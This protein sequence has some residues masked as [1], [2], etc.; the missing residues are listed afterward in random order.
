MEPE[1]PLV[2]NPFWFFGVFFASLAFLHWLLI[3]V[4]KLGKRQWKEIDY[5]WISMSTLA[6]FGASTTLRKALATRAIDL[7]SA[8]LQGSYSTLKFQLENLS[9]GAV[10]RTFIRTEMS[11]PDFDEIEKEFD[12][13]CKYG[14][15]ARS[16]LTKEPPTDERA[17]DD[18][19]LKDRPPVKDAMLNSI[20]KQYDR[21]YEWFLET[22]DAYNGVRSRA[23]NSL[24]DIIVMLLSPHLLAIALALRMT[25]VTGELML[26][27]PGPATVD[28]KQGSQT[29][30]VSPKPPS[31]NEK[32]AKETRP[33]GEGS[34]PSSSQPA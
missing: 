26:E 31:D 1:I 8:R 28:P 20:Y 30:P 7:A 13:V 32:G 29:P 11:P 21:T 14:R 5:I 34:T 17:V 25:K 4:L 10:C 19:A 12:S 2:T 27:N 6:L 15:G 33:S 18:L 3:K 24:F 9:G 16:R 22:V 23:E